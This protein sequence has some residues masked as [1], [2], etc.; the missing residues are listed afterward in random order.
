MP[1]ARLAEAQPRQRATANCAKMR[2]LVVLWWARRTGVDSQSS[3]EAKQARPRR[4]EQ[5]ATYLLR[6]LGPQVR[7]R[8]QRNAACAVRIPP[9][10]KYSTRRRGSCEGKHL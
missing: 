1:P 8:S 10:E 5:L 9:C 2:T 6:S 7:R 3:C 4:V